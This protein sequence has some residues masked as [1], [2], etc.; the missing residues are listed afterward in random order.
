MH[1]TFTAHIEVLIEM[2]EERH[3]SPEEFLIWLEEA[4]ETGELTL[5]E[6]QQLLA[7]YNSRGGR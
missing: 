7:D 3:D 6:V 1:L 4:L 2:S 5:S